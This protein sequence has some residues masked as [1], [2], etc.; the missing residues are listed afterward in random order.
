MNR[1]RNNTGFTLIEMLIALAMMA[2]I[3]S[4]VYGSYAATSQSVEACDSRLMYSERASLVLRLMARQ[5]RCAYAPAADPNSY[6][7]AAAGNDTQSQADSARP[8]QV[9]TERL[10]PVFQGG[11]QHRHGELLSFATTTGLTGGLDGP[12]GLSQIRYR[13]DSITN[14]LWLDCGPRMDRL[15]HASFVQEGHPVLDHVV[16][17]D[18]A[19]HDGQRWLTKWTGTKSRE[20]PHAVRIDLSLLDEA[21]RSYHFG[22]TVRTFTRAAGTLMATN[23]MS[24][25]HKR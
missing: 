16:A 18:V 6:I 3:V 2:M 10:R 5:I 19:F 23:Q 8:S 17:V 20:L 11:A 9:Q 25:E 7:S 15:S 1:N 22:T 12:R 24:R 4:M 14:T 13:L 21:G